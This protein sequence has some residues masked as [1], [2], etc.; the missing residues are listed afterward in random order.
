MAVF[1]KVK[2]CQSLVRWLFGKSSVVH[3]ITRQINIETATS[4]N[5]RPFEFFEREGL[6]HKAAH[7]K[8]TAAGA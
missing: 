5:L 1:K 7:S 3:N 4:P 6:H 8:S 2:N